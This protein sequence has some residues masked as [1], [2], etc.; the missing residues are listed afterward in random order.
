[1]D[2]SLSPFDQWWRELLLTGVLTGA[3]GMPNT[4]ISNTFEEEIEEEE[5]EESALYGARTRKRKR[6][7]M[8][9]GLFDQARRI[10]PKLRSVKRYRPRPFPG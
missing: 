7:V 2:E 5:I 8:R 6:K 1:M 4:A 9:S 3:R 10:S